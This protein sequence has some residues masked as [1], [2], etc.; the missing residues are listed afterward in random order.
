MGLTLSNNKKI[1]ITYTYG[2]KEF[3]KDLIR[4]H[5]K[6]N[7]ANKP[8]EAFWGSPENAEYGWKEWCKSENYGDYNFDHPIRWKLKDGS[9]IYTINLKSVTTINGISK[10]SR[11][12]I[13]PN[14]LKSMIYLNYRQMRNDNIAAVELL[15]ARV[16]HLFRN[17]IEISFNGWDCESIVVLDPSKIIFL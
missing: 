2:D 4:T 3:N 5:L 13:I 6:P 14:E 9:K 7:Y 10:L 11:Y 12:I 16:G 1:Y 17:R 15:D 8:T